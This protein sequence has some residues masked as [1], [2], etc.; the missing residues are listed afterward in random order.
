MPY[1][2]LTFELAW[3]GGACFLIQLYFDF[4]GYSD[5]A[6]GL[7][8]MLGFTFKENFRYPFIARSVTEFWS[9][10]HISMTTWF[11]DYLYAALRGKSRSHVGS[12]VNLLIVFILCGLWHGA[13]WTFAV[14]GV[15][16]GMM[17]V[18]ERIGLE[19]I[20]K[21]LWR[22]L[23]HF[24]TLVFTVLHA[25]LFRSQSFEQYLEFVKAMF[26]LS[27][28][29]SF[30]DFAALFHAEFSIVLLISLVASTPVAPI[31]RERIEML[32]SRARVST[33]I[34][35]TAMQSAFSFVYIAG[36][37]L[38]SIMWIASATHNPFVYFRF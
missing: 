8:R 11:R 7:G 18:F 9:R 2:D 12:F 20:V 37:F 38:L 3:L 36:V 22:P 28:G 25:T 5:M 24:Y 27:V 33:K 14:W 15:I 13:S 23:Q 21:R 35:Y 26:G 31:V 17:L 4:S 34:S 16:N 30:T 1:G 10:W 32:S 29:R 6:I 19:R